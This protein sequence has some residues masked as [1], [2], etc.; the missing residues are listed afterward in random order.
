M[1]NDASKWPQ[2]KMV[3]VNNDR[4]KRKFLQ[5]EGEN[6]GSANVRKAKLDAIGDHERRRETT[7]DHERTEG[8]GR[9]R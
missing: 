2:T 7:E 4:V 6:P 9:P 8:Y 3:D 1:G 5:P